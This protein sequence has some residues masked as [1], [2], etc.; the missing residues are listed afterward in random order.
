MQDQ[1]SLLFR[2][3]AAPHGLVVSTSDP[4][5]LRQQLYKLRRQDMESFAELSFVI[6]PANPDS[7]LWIVK[8]GKAQ[9]N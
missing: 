3:L 6:S 1:Q 7:E 2:A 4:D 8:N 5:R 9:D